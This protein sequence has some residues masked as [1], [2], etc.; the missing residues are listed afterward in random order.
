LIGLNAPVR[1]L[2]FSPDGRTLV[3]GDKDGTLAFW[4]PLTGAQRL[5]LNGH[6][7]AVTSIVFSSDGSLL[8]TGGGG[9]V[10]LWPARRQ[11]ATK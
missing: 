5:S 8:A 7:D 6:S 9:S 3:T 2:A 1:R 4:C 10:R 11:G